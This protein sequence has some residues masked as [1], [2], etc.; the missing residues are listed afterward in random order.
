MLVAEPCWPPAVLWGPAACGALGAGRLRC[1]GG[2]ASYRLLALPAYRTSALSNDPDRL[3]LDYAV[4]MNCTPAEVPDELFAQF[5]KHFDEAQL[6]ELTH[7][8]AMEN[9]RGCFNLALGIPPL[10]LP[11]GACERAGW[12]VTRAYE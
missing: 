2:R 1:F 5:A 11:A 12:M 10:A 3:V 7:V 9:M 6:V 4:G 8:I